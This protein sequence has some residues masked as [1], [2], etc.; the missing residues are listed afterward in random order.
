SESR[1]CIDTFRGPFQWF[2]LP[3]QLFQEFAF[4]GQIQ[5]R[6]GRVT[7]NEI[8]HSMVIVEDTT[9]SKVVGFLE[10]GMLPR[11]SSSEESAMAGEALTAARAAAAVAAAAAAAGAS[12]DKVDVEPLSAS[13]TTTAMLDVGGGLKEDGAVG[14]ERAGGG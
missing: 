13:S 12:G 3:L 14:G 9:S 7:R 10:I 11:P 4:F 5:G 1:L 6:L 8:K 2:E